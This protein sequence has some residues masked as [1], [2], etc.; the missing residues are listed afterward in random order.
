M[1][2]KNSFI[3]HFVFISFVYP[4]IN[5][6]QEPAPINSH[7]PAMMIIFLAFGGFFFIWTA[8][9]IIITIGVSQKSSSIRI[10]PKIRIPS[11]WVV[12]KFLKN[13]D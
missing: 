2:D 3:G 11:I 8:P 9:I 10:S 12:F 4:S 6:P 5:S 1:P 7:I 13:N